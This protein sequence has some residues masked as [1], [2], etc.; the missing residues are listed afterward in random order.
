MKLTRRGLLRLGTAAA[1]LL[2]L[3]RIAR[4]QTYPTRPVR[5]IVGFPAGSSGD[6]VARLTTHWLASRLGQPFVVE[7]RTGAGG[8]IATEVVAR[9][10]SDGYTLLSAGSG[11]AINATLYE[12]L[13]FNFL[14]DIVPV[15]GTMRVPN[16]MVTNL[17]LHT[18][19]VAE[20]I[21][22]AKANPGKVNMA[23]GFNCR[24]KYF[25]C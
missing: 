17:S 19:T 5:W 25:K 12:N 13:S 22:Y 24:T 14:R 1:A 9:A 8:N 10:P 15:A 16:V 11:H 21:A 18:K 4:A 20:F 23:Y 6:T 2:A 3:P 7:N